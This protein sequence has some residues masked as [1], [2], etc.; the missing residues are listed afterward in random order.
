MI[1]WLIYIIIAIF[2]I[3]LIGAAIYGLRLRKKKYSTSKQPKSPLTSE[4]LFKEMEALARRGEYSLAIEKCFL[5]LLKRLAEK[6]DLLFVATKTNGEYRQDVKRKY[7][8]GAE[9][10]DQLS[11]FFDEVWYGK[12]KVGE[13]EYQHYRQDV[14]RFLGEV[15]S[16]EKK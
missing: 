9:M 3:A 1:N 6:T 13:E 15:E 14:L 10:F 16:V 2:V 7:P 8:V 11:L 5:Y 12:K 4:H